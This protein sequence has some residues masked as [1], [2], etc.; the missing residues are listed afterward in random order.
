MAIFKAEV[1]KKKNNG[2]YCNIAIRVTHK[3]KKKY[4]PTP[5][6]VTKDDFTRKLK[7]KNQFYI[8]ETD[9]IIKKYRKVSGSYDRG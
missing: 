8:D 2:A 7:I 4:I 9:K 3:T 6:F 5:F 1:Y